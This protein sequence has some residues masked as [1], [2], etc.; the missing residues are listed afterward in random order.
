[1]FLPYVRVA[2][3]ADMIGTP[4]V[5]NCAGDTDVLAPAGTPETIPSTCDSGKAD[6][7]RRFSEYPMIPI[8]NHL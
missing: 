6:G 5:G 1:V 2:L 7:G 3:S 8:T 4:E